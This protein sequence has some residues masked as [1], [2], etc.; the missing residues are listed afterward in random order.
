MPFKAKVRKGERKS[1]V[2]WSMGSSFLRE[3]EEEEGE[4]K[5]KTTPWSP[6][7]P[8]KWLANQKT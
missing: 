5:E 4:G 3:K 7:H 6:H 8:L 2:S 1:L